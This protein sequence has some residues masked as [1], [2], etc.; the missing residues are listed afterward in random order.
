MVELG[1]Q[2]DEGRVEVLPVWS[3]SLVTLC[4]SVQIEAEAVRVLWLNRGVKGL[5]AS[6]GPV[7]Q[8]F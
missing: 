4:Q 2:K 6:V 8:D 5:I 7:W 1:Q 3:D